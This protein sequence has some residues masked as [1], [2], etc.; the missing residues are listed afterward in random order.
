MDTG[1][2]H[3]SDCEHVY[4]IRTSRV[5]SPD[6]T[7]PDRWL[8]EMHESWRVGL[9]TTVEYIERNFK[10]QDKGQGA[11]CREKP[12]EKSGLEPAA[13][14]RLGVSFE[15]PYQHPP[16]SPVSIGKPAPKIHQWTIYFCRWE[17]GWV[18][19]AQCFR[20]AW[21]FGA[22][23]SSPDFSRGFHDMAL[24]GLFLELSFNVLYC[25]THANPPTLIP[26]MPEFQKQ[27]AP[28]HSLEKSSSVCCWRWMPC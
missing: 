23:G 26:N 13:P 11:P 7:W 6:R 16:W 5:L 21:R 15:Y 28:P 17:F 18:D 2:K 22:A 1:R 3:R 27:P 9:G 10:V 20:S 19:K 4:V 12:L 24:L 8:S 14:N 25:R